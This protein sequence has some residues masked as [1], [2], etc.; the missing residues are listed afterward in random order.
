M[1][2]I[3]FEENTQYRTVELTDLGL[4]V[5]FAHSQRHNRADKFKVG[6][7]VITLE[8]NWHNGALKYTGCVTTVVKVSESR[9]GVPAIGFGASPGFWRLLNPHSVA[10]LADVIDSDLRNIIPLG[11]AS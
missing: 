4:M 9:V 2:L 3:T 6:D 7:A 1:G 11:G 10:F 8:M 5:L